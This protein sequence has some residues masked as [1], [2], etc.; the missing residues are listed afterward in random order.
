MTFN[1]EDFKAYF[2]NNSNACGS[3]GLLWK[4]RTLSLID[5]INSIYNKAFKKFNIAQTPTHYQYLF[6]LETLHTI[7]NEDNQH[8]KTKEL[9]QY[10]KFLPA[11]YAKQS[12]NPITI[13]NHGYI[14]MSV[15]HL[16][17]K[18]IEENNLVIDPMLI[19]SYKNFIILHEK[20]KLE[21]LISI[22]NSNQTNSNKTKI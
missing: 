5:T 6:E 15:S 8:L 10:L 9:S 4:N 7:E 1:A 12:L 17:N 2:D 21:K 11:Y 20:E 22:L 19:C 14:L 13:E 18:Y 16:F 3:T